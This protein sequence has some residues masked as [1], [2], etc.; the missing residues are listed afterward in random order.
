MKTIEIGMPAE[1]DQVD[2]LIHDCWFDINRVKVEGNVFELLLIR[3]QVAGIRKR[4]FF[5]FKQYEIKGLECILKIYSV[6][7]CKIVDSERVD[8]YDFNRLIFDADKYSFSIEC[9]IPV[10]IFIDVTSFKISLT[11][12]DKT[13]RTR[14]SWGI[15]QPLGISSRP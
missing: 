5:I 6:K 8:L 14:N 4:R 10:G 15:I 7:S 12:T 13:A 1:L 9:G 11:L 3:D 2:N